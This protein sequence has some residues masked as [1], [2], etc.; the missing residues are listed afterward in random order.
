M[1]LLLARNKKDLTV[2][3]A[4]QIDRSTPIVFRNIDATMWERLRAEMPEIAE[5]PTGSATIRKLR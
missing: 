5:H 4:L 3:G 1:A 2:E